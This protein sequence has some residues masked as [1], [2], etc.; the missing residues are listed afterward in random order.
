MSLDP[1]PDPDP[2]PVHT[3]HGRMTSTGL[4]PGTYTPRDSSDTVARQ[5]EED[6]E[7]AAD[8][9]EE[10]FMDAAAAVFALAFAAA[11]DTGSVGTHPE[12]EILSLPPV[13]HVDS[14]S[15]SPPSSPSRFSCLRNSS[16][17]AMAGESPADVPALSFSAPDPG[18]AECPVGGA[19]EDEDDNDE[20]SA[21]AIALA[22]PPRTAIECAYASPAIPIHSSHYA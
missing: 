19:D 13:I 8:A 4:C 21:S 18:T 6:E 12:S 3:Q 14:P 5:N 7:A 20:G 16:N 10:E 1:D 17:L 9:E 15:P 2:D 22:V 11:I